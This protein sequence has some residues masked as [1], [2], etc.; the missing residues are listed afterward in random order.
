[1]AVPSR[2][3]G[4]TGMLQHL[5]DCVCWQKALG[6]QWPCQMMI[7]VYNHLLSKVFWFHYHSQ[8]VI[9]SL[10]RVKQ[11]HEIEKKHVNKNVGYMEELPKTR[12]T[13]CCEYY[14][15]SKTACR[16]VRRS[17][18]CCGYAAAC[19]KLRKS[20]SKK[21]RNEWALIETYIATCHFSSKKL[22]IKT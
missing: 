15:T 3:V 22:I 21:Q 1:M 16:W 2:D 17:L 5:K 14:S 12:N 8:K 18:F 4:S 6:I 9:G 11:Q 7:G 19:S 20:T 13:I 10:G